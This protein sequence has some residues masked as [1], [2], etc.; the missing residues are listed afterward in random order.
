MAVRVETSADL[1]FGI[2]ITGVTATHIRCRRTAD[3]DDVV[4]IDAQDVTA[5]AGERLKINAGELDFVFPDGTTG[6]SRHLNRTMVDNL[7]NNVAWQ[8]D[9]MTNA[10]TP[11]AVRGYSQQSHSAWTITE[12]A[13]S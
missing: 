4:L 9:L 3:T 6:I 13:D 7:F 12:E 10:T 2:M 11:I 8:I 1:D 5:A